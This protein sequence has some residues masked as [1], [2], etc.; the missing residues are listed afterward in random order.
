LDCESGEDITRAS[1]GKRQLLPSFK[2]P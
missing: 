2:K 1:L